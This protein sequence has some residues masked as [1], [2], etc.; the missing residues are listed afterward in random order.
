MS[1]KLTLEQINAMATEYNIPVASLRAVIEVEAKGK[2]F[3]SNGLPIILFE[4]HIFYRELTARKLISIRNRVEEEK[5]NLCYKYWKTGKYGGIDAQHHRLSQASEY[6]RDSALSSCSWGL[7][8]VM[9]FN[10]ELLGYSSLQEFV[11]AMYESEAKQLD[12]VLRF[13]KVN[14]L[15]RYLRSQTWHKFALGY[16][17]IGYKKNKYHIKLAQA[18]AKYAE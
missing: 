18:Y 10:W 16:N 3:L 14:R 1:K 6:D 8:Q 4:P 5:P 13:I 9:G 7:G 17:G 2:G 15:D 12:A 11:N